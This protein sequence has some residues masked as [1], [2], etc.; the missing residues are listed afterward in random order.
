MVVE[1]K[2]KMVVESKEE[3]VVEKEEM[4]VCMVVCM[5]CKWSMNY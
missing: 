2:E 5:D 4:V 1:N 3:I